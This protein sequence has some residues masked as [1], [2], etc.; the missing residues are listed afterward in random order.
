[1]NDL[2]VQ[3]SIKKDNIAHINERKKSKINCM[4]KILCQTFCTKHYDLKWDYIKMQTRLPFNMHGN[5]V[6]SCLAK[7][8]YPTQKD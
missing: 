5:T 3:T 7:S 2:E 8:L 4:I 6:H 1:M